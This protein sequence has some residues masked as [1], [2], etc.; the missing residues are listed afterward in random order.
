MIHTFKQT[1]NESIATL[2]SLKKI[3]WSSLFTYLE[4][5]Y[6]LA[7]IS[8]QKLAFLPHCIALNVRIECFHE[9]NKRNISFGHF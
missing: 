4:S 2:E 7:Q 8:D 6:L 1:H 3:T 9:E 5:L